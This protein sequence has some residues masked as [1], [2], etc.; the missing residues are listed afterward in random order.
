MI[1]VDERDFINK[2]LEEK[3]FGVFDFYENS[4]VMSVEDFCKLPLNRRSDILLVDTHSLLKNPKHQENFRAII[5]T[6]TGVIFFHDHSNQE[7]QKWVEGEASF[8]TK[9]VGEYSLPMAQLQWTML[10][11]QLQFFWTLLDEQKK[12]QKHMMIFSQEL[13]HV[14]QNAAVEMARAKKIHEV[15]IPRRHDEIK[16]VYF[17]NKY[18]AGDGGGGEFYDLLQSSGKVFQVMVSSQS[19][20]ISSSLLG[21]LTQHKQKDF[22]PFEFIKDAEAEIAIINGAKKKKSEVEV[23]ILEMD[24]SKLVLKTYGTGKVEFY[25]QK[26]GLV[27]ISSTYQLEK[28][29]NLIVFSSGF[30]FNWKETHKKDIGE[31]LKTQTLNTNDILS[32]LFFQLKMEQDTPFLKRDATVAMMEVKRHG[33]HQV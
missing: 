22:D 11:N 14:L 1:I 12:L 18:A 8:L 13:D 2:A 3:G 30:L 28:G 20:L 9:I 17:S 23:L 31:F 25:S 26:N 10:S 27:Q 7:A 33:I 24:L 16:G 21:L 6:F 29:E 19:Y 15:F 32:E 4:R 5:N